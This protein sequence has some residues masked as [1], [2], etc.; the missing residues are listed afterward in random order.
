MAL[1]RSKT[2]LER[3]QERAG[4]TKSELTVSLVVLCICSAS[5]VLRVF[6]NPQDPLDQELHRRLAHYV[7]SLSAIQDSL[8]KLEHTDSKK[9]PR[10]AAH[11]QHQATKLSAPP[12][13]LLV[14]NS[15][16]KEELLRVP[17]IGPVVAQRILDQRAKRRF[18]AL[19]D[20][21]SI[22]GIGEKLYARMSPYFRLDSAEQRRSL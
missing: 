4:V 9:I 6:R 8:R 3:M 14:L 17:G 22:K 12:S 10:D 15:C 20:L 7:D 18:R 13:P 21:R 2:I 1:R 16:T 11:A 19:K 5:L